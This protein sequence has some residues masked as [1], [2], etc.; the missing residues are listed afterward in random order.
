MAT[1]AE[2]VACANAQVGYTEHPADSNRTKFGAWYGIDGE[3]WCDM[4]VSW[5]ANEV[6]ALGE[7]GKYAY[8]PYHAAF[9]QSRGQYHP[10]H[11]DG[12]TPQAGDVVFFGRKATAV[13]V[14]IVRGVTADGGAVL[15]IEGNTSVSDDDNGGAV[16]LRTRT[17]GD[18]GGAWGILGFGRPAWD[19][20]ATMTPEEYETMAAYVLGYEVDGVSVANRLRTLPHDA[21]IE[22]LGYVNPAMNGDKDVY[23]LVTDT[24]RLAAWDY[25]NPRLEG[26]DAYQIL[27]DVRDL[28]TAEAEAINKLAETVE[29]LCDKIL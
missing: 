15:T 25:T 2:F 8:C 12:F 29:A 19:K 6:G 17:Y 26:V 22:V 23:Q 1:A 16:M 24:R 13:H 28:V 7:V 14:G 18:P 11:E 20:E 4:F 10:A 9:F 21:A 5:V 27:R 3:P